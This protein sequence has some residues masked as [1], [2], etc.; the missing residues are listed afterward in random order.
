VLQER[1][2]RIDECSAVEPWG[3]ML[4]RY[5]RYKTQY[6]VNVVHGDAARTIESNLRRYSVVV[7]GVNNV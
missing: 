2:V 4:L 1:L 3:G 5:N 6:M 7:V